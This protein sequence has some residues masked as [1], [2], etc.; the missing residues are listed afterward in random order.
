MIGGLAALSEASDVFKKKDQK[1]IEEL[2]S[3]SISS[4]LNKEEV[5]QRQLDYKKKIMSRIN[6]MSVHEIYKHLKSV[7]VE[8]PKDLISKL[9]RPVMRKL[10]LDAGARAISRGTIDYGDVID[11]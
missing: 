2:I 6:K 3:N 1:S 4:R 10:L 5:N 9:K 7:N 11:V 8:I